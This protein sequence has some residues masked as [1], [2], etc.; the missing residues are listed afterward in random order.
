[1]NY[2]VL[3][4]S[5]QPLMRQSTRTVL[6]TVGRFPSHEI[7]K[8]ANGDEAI[9]TIDDIVA[10]SG[11]VGAVIHDLGIRDKGAE[12][13]RLLHHLRTNH[14]S[15]PVIVTSIYDSTAAVQGLGLSVAE[16][17]LKAGAYAHISLGENGSVLV[18]W[19][20]SALEASGYKL[21]ESGS[22]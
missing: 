4:V 16:A 20:N 19:V 15:I 13:A 9:R 6:E 10:K 12:I 7:G 2:A 22:R 3:I 5:S 17:L 11:R 18:G 1:M 21:E 14:H 8:A